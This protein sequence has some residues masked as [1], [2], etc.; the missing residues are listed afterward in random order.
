MSGVLK[1]EIEEPLEKIKELLT[2]QKTS[3]S[4]E[5]ILV[6]Y[7]LKSGQARTV[8]ELAVLSGHHRT[9]ISRWLS[10]YRSG[11]IIKLLNIKKSTGR[12]RL[13]PPE[14]ETH[15]VEELKDPEGFE[16][17]EEVKAWLKAIW[18]IEMSYTGVHKLVRYRLKAKLKVPRP[19]HVKQK[20]GAAE[21]FKKKLNEKIKELL[22][23]LEATV[24][25][26]KKVRYWC[27]D[28]SRIGL[29]TITGKKLTMK[30]VQPVGIEQWQF[31]YLWL[32]GRF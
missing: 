26:Y 5:R 19:S 7:W 24:K 15:L 21:A 11:G 17:Y 20:A 8:E 31:K 13:I 27:Q 3:K 9:T 16:S 30:G 4:K 6:L 14:I 18:D 12:Q 22:E 25:R 10:Q 23:V 28:E 32:Y 29:M 2:K 1:I